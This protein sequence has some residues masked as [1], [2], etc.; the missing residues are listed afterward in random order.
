MN[1]AHDIRRHLLAARLQ[2]ADAQEHIETQGGPDEIKR[3]V[4]D[5][6][7]KCSIAEGKVAT[8]AET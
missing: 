1:H 5:L 7:S 4:A 3:D 6:H 8:W 2:L